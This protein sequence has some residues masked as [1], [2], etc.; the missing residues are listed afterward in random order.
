MFRDGR[1]SILLQHDHASG[2]P[3]YSTTE[4]TNAICDAL[5]AGSAI[6][7]NAEI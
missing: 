3:L 2:G 7:K 6:E 5:E 1:E 4:M